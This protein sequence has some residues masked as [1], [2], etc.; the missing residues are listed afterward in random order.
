MDRLL[1]LLGLSTVLAA[2]AP[3]FDKRITPKRNLRSLANSEITFSILL[4][5]FAVP[6][7]LLAGTS[8]AFISGSETLWLIIAA[9]GLA[10]L[11]S[12]INLSFGRVRFGRVLFYVAII[13]CLLPLIGWVFSW[14]SIHHYLKA[15]ERGELDTE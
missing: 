5:F 8:R 12:A 7:Y 9:I 10:W 4:L 1:L 11:I 15:K 6:C 13:R 2:I 14:Y 3:F